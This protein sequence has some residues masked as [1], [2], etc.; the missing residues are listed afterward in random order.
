VTGEADRARLDRLY[1]DYVSIV[2]SGELEGWPD[3]F[4]GD[5]SYQIV[6]RE[7]RKR[8]LPLAVMRCDSRDM[9][10]D[11]VDAIRSSAFYV[12]R[13]VRHIVGQLDV[14]PADAGFEVRA[15]FAVF[16]S[17]PRSPTALLCA[18]AYEDVVVPDDGQLRFR[19]R[20]CIYDGDLVV[21]SIVYPL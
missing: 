20:H 17:R 5:C 18:G 15:N 12:S 19:Q 1:L 10:R 11:R 7:N 2:D 21:D 16:Q 9:L 6:S 3:L 13:T 4:V 14:Q 8:G